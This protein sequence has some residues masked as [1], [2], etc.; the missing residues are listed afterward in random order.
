MHK[1][2]NKRVKGLTLVEILV[3]VMVILV[4]ATLTVG[5]AT[6]ISTQAKENLT[7]GTIDILVTALEQFADYKYRYA[8]EEL[9]EFTFPLDFND[10]EQVNLENAIKFAIGADDVEIDGGDHDRSYS[11]CETMYLFLS[12]VPQSREALSGIDDGLLTSEGTDRENMTITIDSRE[13]PLLRVLDPWNNTLR[14]DY[15]DETQLP[16]DQFETRR[17]FPVITSSGP[18]RIF[19]TD[20]DISNR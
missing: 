7:R 4:L 2:H 20:D 3:V 19:G 10:F 8:R 6:H 16:N 14:Y 17:N 12:M 1:K 15:Y 11:G 13:Y 18:D 5:I 9:R